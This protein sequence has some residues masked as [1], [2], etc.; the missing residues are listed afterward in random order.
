MSF[1]LAPGQMAT[2]L[3]KGSEIQTLARSEHQTFIDNMEMP[4][5]FCEYRVMNKT[6]PEW[7][8]PAYGWIWGGLIG[9]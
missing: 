5:Y 6:E 3:P 2:S 7:T 8:D 4:W 1:Y 9:F